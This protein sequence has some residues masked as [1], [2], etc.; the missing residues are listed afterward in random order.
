MHK[1]L[2]L[3]RGINVSGHK[4]IKMEDLRKLLEGLE[5]GN[6]KTYI[7]S[8]NVIFESQHASKAAN[9]EKIKKGLFT[10]YGFDVGVIVLDNEDLDTVIK[11]N[12]FVKDKEANLKQLYVVYLSETPK[13]ENISRIDLN[14]F[15]PDEFII[16]GRAIY[17][18]FSDSASNSKLTNAFLEKRL[19]VTA[20][21]RNWNT[22]LKLYDLLKQ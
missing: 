3:L 18:K 21:T 17:I 8:G 5:L 19:N 20:T 2:A 6:V 16:I 15:E 4:I 7:Q 11:N 10:Q 1:Q 13:A 22:T 12:P 9:A 14:Q